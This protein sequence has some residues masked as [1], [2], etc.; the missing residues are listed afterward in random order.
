MSLPEHVKK[1]IEV[2]IKSI[3]KDC[4]DRKQ[5][6]KTYGDLLLLKEDLCA[7]L[8]GEV[9]QISDR[10]SRMIVDSMDWDQPCLREFNQAQKVLREH[11]KTKP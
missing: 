4:S 7:I 6:E 3:E 10:V 2:A 1:V 5:H 8:R 11:F 9:K